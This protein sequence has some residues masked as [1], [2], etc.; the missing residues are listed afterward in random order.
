[1]ETNKYYDDDLLTNKIY[2]KIG[3]VEINELLLLEIE[4]QSKINWKM[5][6]EE[7]K[8]YEYSKKLETIYYNKN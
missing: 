1:M 7:V 3:G 6:V 2:S 4:F 8:F 5:M